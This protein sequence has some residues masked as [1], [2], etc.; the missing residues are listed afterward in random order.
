MRLREGRPLKVLVLTRRTNQSVMIGDEIE[1]QILAV[2]GEKVRIGITAPQSIP[3]FR[4]EVFRRI[5]AERA[6]ANVGAAQ[7]P[8]ETPEA[9]PAE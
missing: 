7:N 3:V 6:V 5:Q 1:V 8:A 4:E 2:S 9:H